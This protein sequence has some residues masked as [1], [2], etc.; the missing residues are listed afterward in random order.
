MNALKSFSELAG[1]AMEMANQFSVEC[2][3]LSNA[4]Q[5]LVKQFDDGRKAL[6]GQ[7][8]NADQARQVAVGHIN[9]AF[10]D[11]RDA[12]NT[13]IKE[14][15]TAFDTECINIGLKKESVPLV[16]YQAIK[17]LDGGVLKVTKGVA[18]VNNYLQN[19]WTRANTKTEAK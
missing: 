8:Q 11:K 9:K 15:Q 14:L 6:N 10:A 16:D 12:V 19:L 7:I 5:L 2:A 1:K 3:T 4:Q 17:V 18:G 13:R